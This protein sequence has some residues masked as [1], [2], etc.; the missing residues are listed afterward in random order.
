MALGTDNKLKSSLVSPLK[1]RKAPALKTKATPAFSP[2]IKLVDQGVVDDVN[3]NVLAQ[4][5]GSGRMASDSMAGRGMSA[6]RGQ[7]Y[8]ADLAQGS[9]EADAALKADQNNQQATQQNKLKQ[10]AYDSAMR[11]EDLANQG[12]LQQLRMGKFGESLANQGFAQ[13]MLEA[14]RRGQ[15]ARDQIYTDHTPLLRGLS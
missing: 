12:L 3:N 8:R 2:M 7:Q 4:A 9:A 10:L 13:D 14:K 15:L 11:Q 5:A 6:G 1:P